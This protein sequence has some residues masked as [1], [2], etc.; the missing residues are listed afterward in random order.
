M[1]LKPNIPY[2]SLWVRERKM[3]KM[4]KKNVA[5][6]KAQD[7]IDALVRTH[8]LVQTS[9]EAFTEISLRKLKNSEYKEFFVPDLESKKGVPGIEPAFQKALDE[10]QKKSP[11]GSILLKRYFPRIILDFGHHPTSFF[12]SF[13]KSPEGFACSPTGI[14]LMF[15]LLVN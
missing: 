10:E 5:A 12:N 4:H 2:L 13:Q 7:D 11:K 1:L 8:L 6:K 14:I 15:L 9:E 3:R